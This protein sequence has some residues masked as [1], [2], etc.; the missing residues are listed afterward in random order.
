MSE[1]EPSAAVDVATPCLEVRGVTKH[2]EGIQA[3]RGV[4]ADFRRGEV[5]ALVG[6]NGAGKSTLA[7]V[8]AGV[9]RPDDGEVL[10]DGV[11]TSF[12]DPRA[13]IE[14]GISIVYQ[15]PSLLPFLTVEEN[16]VLGHEPHSGL[17]FVRAGEVRSQSERFLEVVGGRIRPNAN[18]QELTI[19]ERQLVEIAKAL[20]L[21]AEVV[22]MDEPTSSLSITEV[23][24]LE[25]VI[26]RLRTDGVAVI[27]ISH[28]LNEVFSVAD[29]VTVLKDGEVTLSVPIADTRMDDVVRSMVGRDLAH[30]F[31]PR[32]PPQGDMPVVLEVR[33]ATIPGRVEDVSFELRAGEV[34]GFIGLIGAGRSDVARSI[35]GLGVG[36]SGE[37]LLDGTPVRIR[38]PAEAVE[39][40]IALV[41]EDR[42]LEGLVL[43]LSV[44]K[45]VALPQLERL[46]RWSILDRRREQHLADEQ[47]RALRIRARAGTVANELSGGN[48]QK[49]VLSKWLARGCRILLLD[50]PTRGIDIGAK[51][52]IYTLIRRLASDGAAVMLISSE[53]PEILHLADRIVVMSKGRIVGDRVNEVHAEADVAE[54]ERLIRSALGLGTTAPEGPEA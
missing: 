34:T 33:H 9:Y 41:P 42:Q 17:G 1:R 4:S 2:F 16:L 14:A 11:P 29:R 23:E 54:E 20:S 52:E 37:V 25:R 40:G 12:A 19:A 7:K 28:D 45:N 3:L 22:V 30:L 44:A 8:I 36:R 50:E 5:H 51:V 46:S 15:E 49:V 38:H 35:L 32:E 39:L 21:R 43:G 13:A 53:L 26:D 48:Q 18:V 31:P 6:E 27:L 24:R 47:I 10:R